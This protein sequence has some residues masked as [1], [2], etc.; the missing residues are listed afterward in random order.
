MKT[1][2]SLSS[3]P[4]TNGQINYS[5]FFELKGIEATYSP[6]QCDDISN[7]ITEI[8]KLNANGVSI[9][10]PY[11]KSVVD[12][13]D[14]S[15]DLVEEFD[16]CNT[17]LFIGD[18]LVGYNT[19]YYG[20]VHMIDS[21]PSEQGISILG[22]GA[23]GSMF[24]QILGDRATVYSRDTGNWQDRYEMIDTVINCTTF[25]TSTV[26]SP[27]KLLPSVSCVIDLA[28]GPTNLKKQCE[29]DDVKYVAGIEFYKHQFQKQFELYTGISLTQAEVDT[30]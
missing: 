25:G 5:K 13:L 18:R 20:V 21:I 16:S 6:L 15:S 3:Y 12:L 23:I 7:G 11:K 29:A 10:S 17:I 22:N 9:S 24:K 8:K 2:Y 19:D 14:E 30:I 27:F 4:G 28:M 1:F 26:D